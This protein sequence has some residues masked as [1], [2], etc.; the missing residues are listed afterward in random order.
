M[1]RLEIRASV[2]VPILNEGRPY[3]LLMA[4]H[5]ETAH[6]WQSSELN[7]LQQLAAQMGLSLDRV[8]L[9]EQTEQLAKNSATQRRFATTSSELAPGSRPD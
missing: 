3:A 8:L 7:F 9:L 6:H 1:E 5:C 2:E 4:H